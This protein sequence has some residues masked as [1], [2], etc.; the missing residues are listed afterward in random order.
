M[1]TKASR[2]RF[3]TFE[4]DLRLARLHGNG[5]S[6]FLQEQMFRVLEILIEHNG[7][8]ATREEIKKRLW[9]ND[10]VV[11]FDH[12]INAAIRKLRKALDDSAEEP[13][14]IETIPRR[15]YR[16]MAPVEWVSAIEDSAGEAS[17]AESLSASDSGE[18]AES[19]SGALPK[20]RLKVGRLTGKVVSH[21]RV[22]EVIGGGGMG[23][24]Y[25]A[26]DLKLGRAV[27]LKFLPEEVGDDP[28]ARERFNRE[29]H[30]VS[31]LDHPNIC[32]V[33]DFDEYE[34]RPFIAMQLLQ[35]RTLREH[36]ADNRFRLT[37]PEG[38][39][40]AIQIASGLEAAH[41]KG[42]IHRDIKPANIFITEKNVAK[43]LDFGVAKV[44]EN[45]HP[46]KGGRDGAP[47]VDGAP[48]DDVLKG[49]G[50]NEGAG[51]QPRRAAAPEEERGDQSRTGLIPAQS[52]HDGDDGA[53]EGAPL[54]NSKAK[55]APEGVP[56][57]S[58]G[59][60]PGQEEAAQRRAEARLYPKETTLTRTGMKLGTAGYMSPEQVRGEAPDAR[61]DIFSFGLVLYE[62]ATGERAFTGETESIVNDAIQHREPRPV[63]EMAPEITPKL[64]G[65][66]AKCLEKERDGRFQSATDLRGALTEVQCELPPGGA[67]RTNF[68]RWALIAACSVLV[69]LA[70]SVVLL[71]LYGHRTAKLTDKDTI[72]VANFVNRTTD[73]VL[74]GS[75]D[76]ALRFGLEQTP[77]LNLLG[78]D[79]IRGTLRLL[80]QP[81]DEPVTVERAKLICARTAS[82][83]IL[84]PSV[85]DA[86]SLYRL[87]LRVED[88]QTRSQLAES[89]IEVRRRSEIITGLGLATR[90]LREDLGEPR[91]TLRAFDKPL[92]SATST[93]LEALQLYTQGRQVALKS[94]NDKAVSYFS[95]AT[96]LD[97][98]FAYA[99]A[100]LGAA[101]GNLAQWD[102]A[103]KNL[104][105]AYELRGR[106]TE[107]QRFYVEAKY[108]QV[109]GGDYNRAA[110]V[111]EEWIRTYPNDPT[112][113]LSLGDVYRLMGEYQKAIAEFQEGRRSVPDSSYAIHGLFW[114]YVDENR[115]R[116]AT[117]LLDWTAIHNPNES[118]LPY[119]R[120]VIAFMT[121]DFATMKRLAETAAE[122]GGINPTE[123]ALDATY[124]GELSRARRL[125]SQAVEQALQKNAKDVAADH[126]AELSVGEAETGYVRES[127]T[128]AER[129]VAL[130]PGRDVR[131]MSVWALARS[132]NIRR[133]Q[134]L[135]EA[136]EREYPHNRYFA[137]YDLPTMKAAIVWQT[138]PA[139]A[140]AQ[141][142]KIR[143]DLAHSPGSLP[144][145]YHMY[146]RGLAYLQVQR[147]NLAR[148]EFEKIVQHSG[149]VYHFVIGA[150][151]HLQ[152]AR[153]YVMMGDKG[154]A[155][156]SY[157]DF[158][159]LWKDA[160][161][162]IPIVSKPKR[163]TRS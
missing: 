112:A 71:R 155:R 43:I 73:P 152:L 109:V 53:P 8:L 18:S 26:E 111:Y 27:A 147:P 70:A 126:L 82:R 108:Y 74:D 39:E 89:Q 28:T 30:A 11:E 148:V 117:D 19:D 56:L 76:T 114:C 85:E 139:E 125:W 136:L 131:V 95:K 54:Q 65:V 83:A 97:S 72:V 123:V 145:H 77:F 41:E 16:L 92:E 157:Q 7:D 6:I 134:E 162:D 132:G 107:R 93:S 138:D 120:M 44:M 91:E 142:Q 141:L 146:L 57:Q 25:H 87:R 47:A 133:A 118:W 1:E 84:A 69:L 127:E 94:G 163:S 35:G 23:L 81:E 143:Y 52:S 14:Y 64:E 130:F 88:C 49:H 115:F 113:H 50:F 90:R 31:A 10:T 149:T 135:M 140:I 102:A 45:P 17:S 48:E 5:Q 159:A 34:G 55:G 154:A 38:L 99:L 79:K 59:L 75:L 68:R 42:I 129:A 78:E 20:A 36:I 100:V 15:G 110:S 101:Q 2:A 98:N 80:Q 104:T 22:L 158:L 96:E 63:R 124:F 137:D 156:K 61:T 116:E 128:A 151:A 121:R 9:P 161:P 33:Y 12:S 21:Y 60:K 144:N 153:A 58:Q 13:K 62:M 67:A 103:I 106:L 105:Q 160:D 37:Q 32:T 46:G 24:V 3:G 4:L 66:I 119:D 40:V 122:E 29:A 86:G 150:L 51:L